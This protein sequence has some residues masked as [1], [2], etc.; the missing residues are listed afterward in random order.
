MLHNKVHKNHS[1]Y[2]IQIAFKHKQQQQQQQQYGEGTSTLRL[3]AH[4]LFFL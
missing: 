2:L 4:S 3:L 1:K